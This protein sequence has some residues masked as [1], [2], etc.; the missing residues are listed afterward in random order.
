MD[1]PDV[2]ARL[3]RV[4]TPK[5]ELQIHGNREEIGIST[6]CQDILMGHDVGLIIC[7]WECTYL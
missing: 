7:D 1:V 4:E 3:T 5:K 6:H 2:D